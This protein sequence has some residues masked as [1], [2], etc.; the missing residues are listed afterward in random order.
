MK[1]EHVERINAL[2]RSSQMAL[3]SARIS[4]ADYVRQNRDDGNMYVEVKCSDAALRAQKE[5]CA[6]AGLQLSVDSDGYV[7][8]SDN[9]VYYRVVIGRN[10]PDMVFHS[11]EECLLWL[12]DGITSTEGAERDHYANMLGQM[13]KG[14]RVLFY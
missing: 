13:K 4:F 1:K 10:I 7:V 12:L 5:I 8:V 9:A 11:E 6:A 14:K 2:L 3:T